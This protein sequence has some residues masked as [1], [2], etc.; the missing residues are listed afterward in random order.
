VKEIKQTTLARAWKKFLDNEE[1]TPE[2]E[3]CETEDYRDTLQRG[4]EESVSLDDVKAWL[5]A[6]ED[7]PG[8]Q[9]LTEEEIVT[10]VTEEAESSEDE[11]A[12]VGDTTQPTIK[13][14][15]VKYHLNFVIQYVEQSANENVFAYYGTSVSY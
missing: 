3:N 1:T 5:Q 2:V 10:S 11:E 6:D 8:F 12:E 14:S 15:E 13:V 9:I 7:D 4:G